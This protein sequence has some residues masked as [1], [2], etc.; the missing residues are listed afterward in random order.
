MSTVRCKF[1]L[2]KIEISQTRRQNAEGK[3]VPVEL[4]TLVFFPVSGTSIENRLFW[5]ATPSGEIRLGCINPEAWAG[6]KIGHEYYFDA[7]PAP[8]TDPQAR[9]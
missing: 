9:Q 8:V 1:R 2:D 6:F 7:S 5:E 3:W 4:R